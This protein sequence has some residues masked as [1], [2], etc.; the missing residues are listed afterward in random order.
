[1]DAENARLRKKLNSLEEDYKRLQ[2]HISHIELKYQAALIKEG[3][4]I[5]EIDEDYRPSE[6]KL[7]TK[8]LRTVSDLF[9][10]RLYSDI[11]MKLEDGSIMYGHKVILA[12]RS[13]HWGVYDLNEVNT[14][15]FTNISY[16]VIHDIMKWVYTDD[17][18]LFEYKEDFL[19]ELLEVTLR[20]QLMSLDIRC[21]KALIS[22][23]DK[24]NCQKF[25]TLSNELCAD[26]LKKFCK[27]FMS[28]AQ[29]E[30]ISG[31]DELQFEEDSMSDEESLES[32]NTSPVSDNNS[33]HT[34][35]NSLHTD[36]NSLHTD[37]TLHTDN[38]SLHTDNNSLHTD[39]NSLHTDS[40][41][42][43]D[44]NSLHTDNN[45]LQTDSTLHT[46]NNSLHTDNTATDKSP[47]GSNTSPDT[48]GADNT[49]PDIDKDNNLLDADS[50]LAET[51]D[52]IPDAG[53]TAFKSDN[54]SVEIEN[55]AN[56]NGVEAIEEVVEIDGEIS[57]EYLPQ[58][59]IDTCNTM[60]GI[61]TSKE[62]LKPDS[63]SL[64]ENGTGQEQKLE[65]QVET[66]K[67]SAEVKHEDV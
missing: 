61:G 44:N 39:N 33:L 40:T 28:Q 29:I 19:T 24:N 7:S 66:M 15:D 13:K 16:E 23:I 20:F 9:N 1:M 47:D 17:I 64:L 36:N 54:T 35:N 51:N 27:E 49:L 8:L 62:A 4:D 10:N 11:K 30:D 52:K 45:S 41:L 32:D 56:D 34:D 53:N 67:V 37:N 57:L 6:D 38:N 58:A 31:V 5:D 65:K 2:D 3:G 43:T 22:L 21:Q 26:L 18:D 14:L 25:M 12:S 63:V 59:F 55:E 50:T 46:D 48:V 60:N 42:H